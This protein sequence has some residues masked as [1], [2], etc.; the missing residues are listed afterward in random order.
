MSEELTFKN[1]LAAKRAIA[2]YLVKPLAKLTPEEMAKVEE[3]LEKTLNK[4]EV[5]TFIRDYFRG[6]RN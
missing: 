5:M 3:I 4:R 6:Q 2:D 1:A